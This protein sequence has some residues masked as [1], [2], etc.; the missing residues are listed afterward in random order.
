[1]RAEI[2]ANPPRTEELIDIPEL[3]RTIGRYKWGIFG[4]TFLIAA[5]AALAAYAVNP[6]YR[7]S[8]SILIELK[9][10]RVVQ[11][12]DV[13]DPGT[14]LNEYYGTQYMVLRSREMAERIV[15]KLQLVDH[16][17]F[18]AEPE[19]EGW[20]AKLDLRRY[21][22]LPEV[23]E[24]QSTLDAD[25]R[26]RNA[27]VD[28][29]MENLT[30]EPVARTQIIKVH[31]DAHDPEL[32][33]AVPNALAELYIESGLEAKLEATE[34]AAAWLTDKLSDIR[35]KLARSEAALQAFLE[36][37]KL[38][39]VG[40]ARTLNEEMLVDYSRRLREAQRERAGLQASYERIRSVGSDPRRLRDI[41]Q[42]QADPLVE[43]ASQSY[44]AA[45]EAVQQLEERYGDKH[46]QMATARARLRAAESAFNEQALVAAQGLKTQ[47]EL[48]LENE[49]VLRNE[50]EDA[51]GQI[52]R[53]DRKS[54]ELSTLERDVETN[55]ELYDTFLTRF[56][57][58]D[59]ASSYETLIARVV[60][61]AIVPQKPAAPR[62]MRWVMIGALAGFMLSLILAALHYA[63][64]EGIRSA[65]ELENLAQ[66]PVFGVLPLVSGLVG[67]AKNIPLLYLQK[68]RTPLSEGVRSIRAALELNGGGKRLMVTSAVPSEGKS[69]V[70]AA[71][72]LALAAN[73]RVVLV[74]TDLRK[75]SLRRQ[76]KLPADL[77]G[78]VDVLEKGRPLDDCLHTYAAGN[79]V[80]LHAGGPATNPA[81]LLSS[82]AFR[83]L[84]EQLD[85]RFDRVLL[86]SP[87]CQ[88]AADA[89]VLARTVQDVLFV[90]KSESTGRRAI[91]SSLKQMRYVG[92][93]LT[94]LVINQ[95]DTRRNASYAQGYYY[96]YN[97]Y[98]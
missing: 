7:G 51:R 4:I 14:G 83:L 70:C 73:Q 1:M 16:P 41:S 44:L 94:G 72:A 20:M 54:Y 26:R 11:I 74:E 6:V 50:V 48:A 89:L 19:A 12:Q 82:E 62:K 65:D 84:L 78:L 49:R 3:F 53:L 27:T 95:V 29:V 42:L 98:Q 33:A 64:S 97:Y 25:E 69:S 81:E 59:T 37:E 90:V 39:N 57:E 36:E 71:L 5:L 17:E 23:T 31:Y 60:D 34:K 75:P 21:L 47:Y 32:A 28:A 61:P 91:K 45:Q 35:D 56:K 76:L 2:P 92:A 87:P 93:P 52:R 13:F 88:A 68:P 8:V 77:P 63:L 24:P 58:T 15:D 67:R 96:A 10:Q 79:I 30:I 38:V 9:S 18:A 46:P 80:V 85:T 55:R 40:G 66:L 22:P 43:A 86:D